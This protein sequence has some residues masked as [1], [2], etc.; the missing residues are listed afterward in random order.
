MDSFDTGDMWIAVFVIFVA[1][2]VI[3][4]CSSM[5]FTS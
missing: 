4:S 1:T 2:S 3:P 5:L